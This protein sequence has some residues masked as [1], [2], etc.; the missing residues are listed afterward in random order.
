[1]STWAGL[2]GSANVVSALVELYAEK[3]E[4]RLDEGVTQSEHARQTGSLAMVDGADAAT[5]C[6][7]LLHDI[8]HLLVGEYEN[9]PNNRETDFRHENVGARF[10][11][12]WFGH[13]V[14]EPVRLHVPA[15][16]FLCA[17]EPDYHE[18]LSPASV[19]SLTLQGGPMSDREI[20]WFESQPFAVDAVR[21]RR[22]DDRG[23]VPGTPI[24]ELEAFQ[25][26]LFEVLD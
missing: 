11:G 3:G 2:T 8:G 1:M 10:L 21:V 20:E 7:A 26:V 15:K 17:V 9:Q 5:I 18:S 6:A 14:T 23:K 25:S 24:P 19:H 12:R 16:R 22:W 4:H 13:A